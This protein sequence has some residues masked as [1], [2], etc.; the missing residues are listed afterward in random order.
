MLLLAVK[1]FE[2]PRKLLDQAV[3]EMRE[4]LVKMRQAAAEVMSTQK[5]LETKYRQAQ[6]SAVSCNCAAVSCSSDSQWFACHLASNLH[7][8]V[9]A[10]LQAARSRACRSNTSASRATG[11]YVW[12]T[13]QMRAG[14]VSLHKHG[15][16]VYTSIAALPCWC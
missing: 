2:D 11:A 3:S 4:D 6:A 5:M 10:V 16:A 7:S 9:A 1:S 12:L 15:E 13:A 14:L 8:K